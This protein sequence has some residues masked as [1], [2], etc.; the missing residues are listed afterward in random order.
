MPYEISKVMKGK[1]EKMLAKLREAI[2]RPV[3]SLSAEAWVT[4]EPMP[5]ADRMQGKHLR[6]EPGD[7]WGKLWDCAWF[8][9]EGV[10]PETAAGLKVV[11][12]IDV[13]GELCLVDEDGVP[14]QGLTN[15]NSE[16]DFELGLP[17]K[18][19]VDVSGRAAGGERLEL[20]A[21]AGCNDLFGR[22]RSGTLKEADIAVC[23]EDVRR[24][25]YD[26]EVL[27]ELCAHVPERS[28]RRARIERKLYEAANALAEVTPESVRRAAELLAP[29]LKRRGGDAELRVSAIGHAHIDLAW[30]WPIRETIRK[31][32]RTFS[33]VLRNMEKY[34]DYVFGASQP[35]LYEWMK[36]HYPKLYEQ[37]KKKVREGRWELQGAMWVEPDTNVSG[38]EALVRQILYGKR[39][40]R[41]EFGE[42][43]KTLWLPDVFGYTA[44]LPQLLAGSGV[45]YMMTQKLSWSVYNKFQHH[46]FVW[47]GI[48]GTGVLTHLPPEDTYNSPAAPRSLA[49]IEREYLDKSVSGNALMLF[50][51]G[52]GGGGPGEEHLERL[53]R[54]KNLSG[55][56]PVVQE[57]SLAFFERLEKE[58]S[59]FARYRGELYLERHQGT[60]TSQA[61]NKRYNRK[62][63]TELRE[64][65]FAS[66]L[67]LALG[68][69]GYPAQRIERIWKEALLY[70]FH[71]ILPGSSIGRVY[72]E[73]L[74]RY[75]IML[76][77]TSA[78]RDAAYAEAAAR[79]GWSGRAVV[80][81]S[82]PWEREE[83]VEWDGAWHPVRVPAMGGI[84]LDEAVRQ[85]ELSG[86]RAEEG[87][88]ANARLQVTFAPDGSLASVVDRKTGREALR[89]G[90]P[91]NVLAVYHDDGDAWDFPR[92]YRD[93]PAGRMRLEAAAYFVDGHRAVAEHRY[94]F[95]E[96]TLT[97]R[98]FVTENGA[99]VEFDTEADW[100]E[101]GKMLRTSFAT[102]VASDTAACEI[103][104]GYLKRPTTRNSLTEMAKDEI[105]AHRYI[106]LSQPDFGVALLNDCKYGHRAAD[107]ELDLNLLRSSSSPDPN[108]DRA[109][110]RFRY[111]LLPHEGD[112][113]QAGVARKGY[114]MNVP[115]VMA[116]G[117]KA[118]R[119][120][121]VSGP[122]A[123]GAAGIAAGEHAAGEAG[124]EGRQGLA[125]IAVDHP[126]LIVEAVKKA[127]DDDRL[128]VRLYESAGASA[129]GT[130]AFGLPCLDAEETNLMEEAIAPLPLAG[131]CIRLSFRPFEIKTI[132]VRMN[133]PRNFTF[134]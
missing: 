28:S 14:R 1:A 111:A 93:M 18:R 133:E 76:A 77:E 87:V 2:Y 75:A 129:E 112:F 62:L 6:L 46:S 57:K 74:D 84:P 32:A 121:I 9:F 117:G 86:L 25:Y 16:F 8:R 99:A 70:Q 12:L 55:L 31:G 98:V 104:F 131:G 35:Q 88:I 97:Q 85:P 65:E 15:V 107:G 22:Y 38:G 128:I 20:W 11:L 47:E 90:G 59:A 134:H 63:E 101:S 118:D 53:A 30:L 10:V 127:E 110:H 41:D 13:N 49:K 72:D 125:W 109:T 48:D 3:G 130:I 67:A 45:S 113:I 54:E 106:D 64:L 71:D 73:S 68:G 21:D 92:D 60:L 122:A 115:L 36:E 114:E 82:L 83:W 26:V 61:R 123:A 95:G 44:S 120:A 7:R 100:R 94:R 17:G 132:R 105:C 39:F 4:D 33:T 34:P 66:S 29:E 96:S 24:L 102:A 19:V 116:V 27:L 91:G 5:F 108:A 80:F 43:V 79:L 78:L 103:Q 37:I 42:D 81:N 56:P 40:F 58:A 126:H 52:D 119:A 51:I 124:V 50:G 89:P 23:D 69:S